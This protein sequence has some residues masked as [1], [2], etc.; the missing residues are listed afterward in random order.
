M[1]EPDRMTNNVGRESMALVTDCFRMHAGQSAKEK[2]TCQN[3][4]TD[5]IRMPFPFSLDNLQR[6]RFKP[7]THALV[8]F[9]ICLQRHVNTTPGFSFNK[10]F[11]SLLDKP[12]T[13]SHR[14]HHHQ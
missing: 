13:S 1:V 5:R 12:V 10:A 2:L 9:N 4:I 3:R 7:K 14:E 8:N 6:L 11:H